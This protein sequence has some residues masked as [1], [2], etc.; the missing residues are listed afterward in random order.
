MKIYFKGVVKL[1]LNIFHFK[2][3]IFNKNIVSKIKLSFN[4]II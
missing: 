3:E 2:S 1:Y 4:T